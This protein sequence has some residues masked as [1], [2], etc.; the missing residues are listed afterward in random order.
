MNSISVDGHDLLQVGSHSS[1]IPS[2]HGWS[3]YRSQI[4]PTHKK[5]HG[6]EILRVRNQTSFRRGLSAH[7]WPFAACCS[8]WI[9]LKLVHVVS[10]LHCIDCPSTAIKSCSVLHLTNLHYFVLAE[11]WLNKW[12]HFISV[13]NR[14]DFLP[15]IHLDIC[16]FTCS[17][18]SNREWTYLIWHSF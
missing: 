7:H 1:W 17:W 9:Q 13:E 2:R 15:I 3:F 14:A 11:L 8:S 10:P 16:S 4:R 12:T 18:N 6:I 5:V